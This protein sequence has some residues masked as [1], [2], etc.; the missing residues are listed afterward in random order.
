MIYFLAFWDPPAWRLRV[1]YDALHIYNNFICRQLYLQFYLNIF[2]RGRA[3]KAKV[4]R[5]WGVSLMLMRTRPCISTN[6]S[7]DKSG[8]AVGIRWGYHEASEVRPLIQGA[9]QKN[10]SHSESTKKAPLR[11]FLFKR[12]LAI[13]GDGST[14]Q[15]GLICPQALV[16]PTENEKM[17]RGQCTSQMNTALFTRAA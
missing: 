13:I 10:P 2:N 9:N 16:A 5:F 4:G 3:I 15:T 6:P 8:E 17:G 1:T 14:W 11:S 12:V 7:S